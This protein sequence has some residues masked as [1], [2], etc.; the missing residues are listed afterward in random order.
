MASYYRHSGKFGVDGLVFGLLAGMLLAI[1][2]AFLYDYGIV[3]IDSAKL[4]ILCP[5]GFGS[6]IGAVCGSAMYWTKVR[7][8][9]V[10]GIVGAAA[11]FFALYLSWVAWVL[12]LLYPTRWLFN[13]TLP[14]LH[15]RG[16]WQLMVAINAKGTWSY[17]HGQSTTGG[18][19]WL[20]WV[21]EALF[22]VGF[23]A[24]VAVSLIKRLPF[25][26]RCNAWANKRLS[27]YISPSLP[28]GQ[29]KQ[30]VESQDVSLLEKLPVGE[31]KKPHFRV[32]LHTCGV[33][34]TLNT[35]SLVQNFPR[36]HK[37]LVEK[38]LVTADQ[39]SVFRNLEMNRS[40]AVATPT[41]SPAK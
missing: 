35:L 36:N 38:L 14:A 40:A 22:V 9:V 23:G 26:E 24:L 17:E 27:L 30:E 37:T 16:L 41:T 12:H 6:L 2:A 15:P 19:L 28:P 20:I 25:C 33:C 4:R 39:A 18:S 21:L 3:E 29:I 10:A 7:S 5:M 34:H 11:S 13:L 8:V 32:D 31:K 1:P